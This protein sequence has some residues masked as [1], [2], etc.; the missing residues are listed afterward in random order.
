[1]DP[2]PHEPD[3]GHDHEFSAEGDLPDT[4]TDAVTVIC[5]LCGILSAEDAA[6]A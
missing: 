4:G 5:V 1:M 2:Y 6:D 3:D